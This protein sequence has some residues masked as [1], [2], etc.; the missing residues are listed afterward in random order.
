MHRTFQVSASSL[1]LFA[2]LH[3][4]LG[5]FLMPQPANVD[6]T[7]ILVTAVLEFLHVRLY[8]VK[9][10]A[11]MAFE[12]VTLISTILTCFKN[13]ILKMCCMLS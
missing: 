1:K 2:I 5:A 7:H 3:G 10:T 4:P 8:A 11:G 13:K 12:C 6:K 9:T